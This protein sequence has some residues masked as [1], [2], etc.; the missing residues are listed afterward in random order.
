M[1]KENLNLRKTLVTVLFTTIMLIQ[2]NV[3]N[4]Q[5]NTVINPDSRFGQTDA[6]GNQNTWIRSIGIGNFT[7]PPGGLPSDET[8]AFLHVQ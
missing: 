7:N 3:T 6:N 5:F 4:A 2:G 1:G 8:H